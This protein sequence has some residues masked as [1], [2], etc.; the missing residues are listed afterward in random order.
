VEALG[1]DSGNLKN[2]EAPLALKLI[3]AGPEQPLDI[4]NASRP[5]E[6]K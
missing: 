2:F 5:G 4:A 3:R 6:T 1:L